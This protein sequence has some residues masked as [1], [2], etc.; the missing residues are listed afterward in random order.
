MSL[1]EW[2][3]T[4]LY[5]V[6][7]CRIINFRFTPP[8]TSHKE[9]L[10]WVASKRH[11]YLSRAKISWNVNQTEWYSKVLICKAM[12]D[13]VFPI[14][15]LSRKPRHGLLEDI[16]SVWYLVRWPL[17][18]LWWMLWAMPEWQKSWWTAF[19]DP[20]LSGTDL[21]TW[22]WVSQT[23][24]KCSAAWKAASVHTLELNQHRTE[25]ISIFVLVG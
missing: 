12:N 25:W 18:L 10:R 21:Y 22:Q 5:A 19:R 7:Y 17:E 11:L 4:L 6:Y 15:M 8:V 1:F 3:S 24:D 16:R 14:A 13:S 9:E 23:L 20:L 2:G